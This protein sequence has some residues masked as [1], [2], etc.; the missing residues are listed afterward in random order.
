MTHLLERIR[1]ARV[2]EIEIP[3]ADIADQLHARVDQLSSSPL[4]CG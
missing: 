3:L 1:Q 4:A 2:G